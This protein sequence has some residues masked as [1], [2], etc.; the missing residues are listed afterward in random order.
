VIRGRTLFIFAIVAS[1]CTRRPAPAPATAATASVSATQAPPSP[2]A[3]QAEINKQIDRFMTVLNNI[4]VEV[5]AY[6]V[7]RLSGF[8][9]SHEERDQ[10]IRLATRTPGVTAVLEDLRVMPFLGR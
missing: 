3:L 1:A 7:V 10:A 2:A 9:T 6:G 5:D 4:D 8:V